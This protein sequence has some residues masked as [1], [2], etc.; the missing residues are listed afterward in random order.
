MHFVRCCRRGAAPV[1][2]PNVPRLS[3]VSGEALTSGDAGYS[4]ANTV[5]GAVSIE[6]KGLGAHLR[7]GLE[8][9]CLALARVLDNPRA[10]STKPAAA[11]K[12]A[13]LLDTLRKSAVTRPKFA[14]V[15]QMTKAKESGAP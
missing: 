8:A 10:T 12:L 4:P 11:A 14:S 13:H 5:E 7:P 3:L 1:P 15:R 9:A 2:G 6:I